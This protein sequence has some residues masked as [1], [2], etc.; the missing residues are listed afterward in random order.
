MQA[1]YHKLQSMKTRKRTN[2][3]PLLNGSV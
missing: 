2:K 3:D 1:D